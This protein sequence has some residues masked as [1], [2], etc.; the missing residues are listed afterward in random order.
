MAVAAVHVIGAFTASFALSMFLLW[1]GAWEQGRLQKRRLQDA[2]IALGVPVSSL[3]NEEH[4]ARLLQYSSQR[5]SGDLF[6]NRLSDLCGL[7][8]TAWGYFGSLLQLGMICLVAWQMYEGG[9]GNAVY[10]WSILGIAMFFWLSSVVFSFA[11]LLLTGRYPGEAKGARKAIATFIEQRP[12]RPA[13]G[14]A[15][16]SSE[17]AW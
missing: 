14:T 17:T 7:V 8:R 15:E 16:R 9:S 1:V 13:Y 5:F 10:M 11:C 6:K 3:E 2:S 4:V 12:A